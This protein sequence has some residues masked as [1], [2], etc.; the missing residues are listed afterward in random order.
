M[1][2]RFKVILQTPDKE[3]TIPFEKEHL[4]AADDGKEREVISLSNGTVWVNT[5]T[6]KPKAVKEKEK[7]FAELGTSIIRL[8][9][10]ATYPVDCSVILLDSDKKVLLDITEFMSFFKQFFEIYMQK[11]LKTYF[12]NPFLSDKGDEWRS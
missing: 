4:A 5:F 10:D 1:K 12:E 6:G 8:I 11:G 3:F 7:I 9:G 2:D